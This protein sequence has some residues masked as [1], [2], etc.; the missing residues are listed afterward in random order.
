MSE[1]T[2]AKILLRVENAQ[3]HFISGGEFGRGAVV[4][5]LNG[6][7]LSIHASE[8]FCVVGESGCGKSTLARLIAG[9]YRPSAGKI[10]FDNARIDHL[11][12]KQRRQLCR[13]IQMIFQDPRGS[14][15]P[16]MTVEQTLAEALCFHFGAPSKKQLKQK[17]TDVLESTGLDVSA[18]NRYPHQFSGGQQQRISIARALIVEPRF[19]IAD[20]PI[21]ALD[22]SVQAQILNLLAD[23]RIAHQIAYLFITHDLSIVENFG[24]QVAVM[25][26]GNI[27]ER[28]TAATL[29]SQP[30]HPYTRALLDA[31]PRIGKPLSAKLLGEP[32]TPL[33]IPTG[34]S[35][36]PRCPHA[37]QRCHNETPTL[38]QVGESTIACHAVAEG[39]I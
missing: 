33:N 39:R 37:N 26:L 10:F 6:V 14:L 13:A 25:Y 23:L 12:T 36:H 17:I 7:S 27:V 31:A 9:L 30:R 21:A 3:K 11:T 24:D 34:C 15:N 20:E 32:P 18:A 19:I 29:F 2:T 28:A 38:H 8:V 1:T 16:R 4:N 5:A 22:V 35:F